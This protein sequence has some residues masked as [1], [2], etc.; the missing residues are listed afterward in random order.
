MSDAGFQYQNLGK[1]T[2]FETFLRY[3]DEKEQSASK[4]AEVLV[5]SMRPGMHMLDIGTGNGEYLELFLSKVG[6][7]DDIRLTLVEP[8][9]D[10]SRQLQDRFIR[11]LHRQNL[12]VV[13]SSL[14]N[15]ATDERFDLILMSHLFYHIPAPERREQIERAQ[16][17][18]APSGKLVVVLRE[19]D[20]VYDF[21]MA[22]KPKLFSPDF[23]ALTLDDILALI[24]DRESV[25]AMSDSILRVPLDE[26]PSDAAAILSFFLDKEWDAVPAEIQEAAMAFVRERNGVLHLRDGIAIIG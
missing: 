25:R 14:D 9:F 1:E 26:Q 18:L 17:M 4:L 22:F 5:E 11:R 3:S 21:K 12:N 24:P 6:I 23:R 2:P 20:D 19:K 10:L 7:P 8:S 16:S 13:S 15:Y